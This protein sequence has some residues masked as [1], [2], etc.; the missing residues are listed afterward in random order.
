MSIKEKVAYLTG[1][2]E[3]LG[4][5]AESKEGKLIAVII[6]TLAD[7]ADEL[8]A[9]TENALDIGE[10]LDALSD[11]LEDVEEFLFDEDYDDDYDFDDDDDDDCG[12]GNCCGGEFICE[13]QCPGCG[14]EIE[15]SESDLIQGSATCPECGAEL[16]F[17]EE[18][19][20]DENAE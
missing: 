9:L 17:E 8:D 5:D 7:M 20:G 14:A 1:L 3:G 10:E 18:E 15:I 6:D 19:D 12:C 2:A 16:D 4:L 13:A 11:S